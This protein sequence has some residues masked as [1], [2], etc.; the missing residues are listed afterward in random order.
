M[1]YPLKTW[2][3]NYRKFG[4]KYDSAVHLGYDFGSNVGDLVYSISEGTILFAGHVGGFGS[5][6]P[7]TPGGAIIIK[8]NEIVALYGHLNFDRGTKVGSLVKTGDILGTINR[9]TSSGE[10]L[11]HL[12]FGIYKGD[13]IPPF[14][15]G[16][17]R[18]VGNWID[19]IIYVQERLN[20]RA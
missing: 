18:S 9:F 6:Y 14:P 1:I 11:P 5:L 17:S 8:H 16:Y 2:H 4:K 19:P 7:S 15:W 20:N 10:L 12:H 13:S 3:N